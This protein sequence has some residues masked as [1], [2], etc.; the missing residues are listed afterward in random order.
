MFTLKEELLEAMRLLTF[1]YE[2][3]FEGPNMLFAAKC[4]GCSGSC[5]TSCKTTCRG[6]AKK[7]PNA[8]AGCKIK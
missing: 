6:F 4:A 2:P 3:A 8:R 7:R 1:D 5:K